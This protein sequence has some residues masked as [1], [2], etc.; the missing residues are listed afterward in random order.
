MSNSVAF[1]Y[2]WFACSMLAITGFIAMDI[3][4]RRRRSIFKRSPWSL[5]AVRDA[6]SLQ[7][8][9]RAYR[10]A[11]GFLWHTWIPTSRKRIEYVESDDFWE[12]YKRKVAD[13][14]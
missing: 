8:Y 3:F 10:T 9:V 14:T 12:R 1:I 11:K 13:A 7:L 5:A 2:G 4:L 6:I